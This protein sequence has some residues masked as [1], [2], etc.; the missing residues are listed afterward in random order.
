MP[1]FPLLQ[2]SF[3]ML[4]VWE[5]A[6][7]SRQV[8]VP[9]P[10]PPASNAPAGKTPQP[11]ATTTSSQPA[12]PAPT[13]THPQE[14]VP[15]QVNKPPQP[16]TAK[17][18]ARPATPPASPAQTAAAPPASASSTAQAW[19]RPHAR[20]AAAVHHGHRSKPCSRTGQFER[21]G[22]ASVEHGSAS[23]SGTDPQLHETGAG[24]PRV[25]IRQARKVW[26]SGPRCWRAI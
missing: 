16:A 22:S 25:R 2:A 3:V 6:C 24:S 14:S 8:S 21:S 11:A 7:Q 20:R 18:P 1:R 26:P 12:S 10:S 15:Y 17:K 5:S 23:R 4:L 19:R 9:V 13:T